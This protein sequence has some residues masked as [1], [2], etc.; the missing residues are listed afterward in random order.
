[1]EGVIERLVDFCVN[2]AGKI[3]AAAAIYFVGRFIIK[4]LL[5]F[6]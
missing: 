4:K 3:A 5:V 2:A 1:M 6:F